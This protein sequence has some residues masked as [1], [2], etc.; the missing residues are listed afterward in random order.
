MKKL[1]LVVLSVFLGAFL[2]NV[3]AQN[4]VQ[5]RN[6]EQ[7]FQK[8]DTNA[9][10]KVSMEEFTK[11]RA[12]KNEKLQQKAVLR[13]K[14]LDTNS[15]GYVSKEEFAQRQQIRKKAIFDKIDKNADGCISW[16]EFEQH[17]QQNKKGLFNKK[18][19]NKNKKRD[20]FQKRANPKN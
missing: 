6:P 3:N 20:C 19:K 4:Q 5:K 11:V 8:A 9:D 2:I 1:S 7:F 17:K 14:A 13:F 10:G 12:Q 18:R 16:Q 15:D